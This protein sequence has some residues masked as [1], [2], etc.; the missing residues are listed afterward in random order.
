MARRRKARCLARRARWTAA[1]GHVGRRPRSQGGTRAPKRCGTW[2]PD[3]PR[4]RPTTSRRCSCSSRCARP[5]A[6]GGR[7]CCAIGL[8][9]SSRRTGTRP[10][11]RR[12]C[13]WARTSGRSSS[14]RSSC[15]TWRRRARC[16][17]SSSWAWS[18]PLPPPPLPLPPTRWRHRHRHRRH[19][20]TTSCPPPTSS[21]TAITSSAGAGC[22]RRRASRRPACPSMSS[23]ATRTP[24]RASR[25]PCR[26]RQ[27]TAVRCA[28]PRRWNPGRATSRRMLTRTRSGLMPAQR[29][30]VRRGR[31]RGAPAG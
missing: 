10:A 21:C 12:S 2:T 27:T 31:G 29:F 20:V 6:A 8:P 9:T 13:W 18:A 1:H 15:S 23:S 30:G 4:A 3:R 7:A 28:P 14:G 5:L 24:R 11:G 19:R 26:S 17:S 22:G 16:A 25:W